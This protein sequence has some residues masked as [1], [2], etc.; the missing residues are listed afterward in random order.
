MSTR[1]K[2][3]C[4]RQGPVGPSEAPGAD[5]LLWD[6]SN[7][8]M[9]PKEFFFPQ[10]ECMMRFNNDPR[11][12]SNGHDHA[13]RAAPERGSACAL[14]HPSLRRQ[15]LRRPGP[16][17]RARTTM[18]NDPYWRDKREKTTLVGLACNDPCPSC[19]CTSMNCGPPHTDRK[20]RWCCSTWA[21]SCLVK[22]ITEKGE[23][24]AA[25]LPEA[26]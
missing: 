20:R 7:T 8:T 4:E 12:P 26:A 6:F 13:G 24:V 9:S 3:R 23:A 16:D 15:G 22:V 11:T 18:T 10:T 21:T 14:G 2:R 25:G 5:G 17:L 19:F 1:P